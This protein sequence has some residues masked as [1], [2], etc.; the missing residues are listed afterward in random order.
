M[1]RNISLLLIA[2][3]ARSFAFVPSIG[4]RAFGTSALSATSG[5][6]KWFNTVKGFGFIVP[7]DGSPDVFV[8]QTDI[9]VEGFRSLADGEAVEFEIVEGDDGRR[10]AVGVTGPGG[11]D[12]QGAPF[13]PREENDYF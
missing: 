6:V 11:S 2:L 7:D 8:H 3:I 9:S 13:R 10:K 1:L 12:V 4:G 5:S